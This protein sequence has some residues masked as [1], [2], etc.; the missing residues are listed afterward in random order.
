M[1]NDRDFEC[2]QCHAHFSSRDALDQHN[3]QQH[4]RQAGSSSNV[5]SMGSRQSSSSSSNINNRSD[6]D[7][8]R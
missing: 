1:A 6:R 5:S 2:Q 7:L 4:S 8:N 3:K